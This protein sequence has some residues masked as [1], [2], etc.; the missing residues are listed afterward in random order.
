[1]FHPGD[2]NE[3]AFRAALRPRGCPRLLNSHRSGGGSPPTPGG[4]CSCSSPPL[5]GSSLPGSSTSR[6]SR[7]APLGPM[8]SSRS[9][10]PS[11]SS[12]TWTPRSYSGGLSRPSPASLLSSKAGCASY[13]SSGYISTRQSASVPQI[14]LLRLKVQAL[15][16]CLRWA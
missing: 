8:S 13:L 5:P 11:L 3:P 15:T 6:R 12:G 14:F 1:M 10:S 9:F 4:S 16:S 7:D 2:T